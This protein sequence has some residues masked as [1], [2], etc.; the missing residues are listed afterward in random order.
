MRVYLNAGTAAA[1]QFDTDFYAQADGA[2]FVCTGAGYLGVF[3]RVVYWDGD[4]RKD[5]LAALSDGTVA[6]FP[7]V[8]T[9]ADRTS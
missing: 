4:A 8:G 1:P 7:N 6:P 5:L 3:P 2:D 9:D